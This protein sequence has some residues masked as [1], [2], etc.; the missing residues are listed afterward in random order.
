MSQHEANF[1]T[2][3]VKGRYIESSINFSIDDIL[4][5]VSCAQEIAI[6]STGKEP[7]HI[8]VG[9]DVMQRLCGES[10]ANYS[11]SGSTTTIRGMGITVVPYMKGVLPV[12][13]D[14]AVND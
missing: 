7:N 9:I 4:S 11:F 14:G 8:F 12:Y 5:Y 13:L 2:L 6:R 1:I 3:D 10:V